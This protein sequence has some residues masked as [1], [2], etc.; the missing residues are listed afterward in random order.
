[1]FRGKALRNRR[2]MRMDDERRASAVR[3]TTRPAS[4]DIEDLR[5]HGAPDFPEGRGPP[6]H[7]HLPI[8]TRNPVELVCSTWDLIK[9]FCS[10][11]SSS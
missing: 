5:L 6:V 9:F 10:P 2:Q 11:S 1:M 4:D 8:E 7:R 3:A